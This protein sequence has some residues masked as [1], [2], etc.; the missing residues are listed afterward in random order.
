VKFD[1]PTKKTLAVVLTAVVVLA[2]VPAAFMVGC[3][4]PMI[5]NDCLG[6]AM[7]IG[8]TL[9]RACSG[10]FVT[11]HAVEGLAAGGVTFLLLL[12]FAAALGSVLVMRTREAG[13]RAYVFVP[14][15]SPPPPED[16]LGERLTL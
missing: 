3:N 4:L 7:T 5:G 16:P 14:V 1:E 15:V 9:S 6:H 11:T 2:A 12:M 10:I 13:E 8:Q